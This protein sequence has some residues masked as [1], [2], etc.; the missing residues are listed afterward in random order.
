MVNLLLSVTSACGVIIAGL[1]VVN[2]RF[3]APIYDVVL[4]LV[5]FVSAVITSILLGHVLPA[6]LSGLTV[7]AWVLLAIRTARTMRAGEPRTGQRPAAPS[8]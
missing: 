4:N 3:V 6:I 5:A 2:R 8:R 1:P 7:A